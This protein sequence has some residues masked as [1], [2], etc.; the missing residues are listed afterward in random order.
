MIQFSLNQVDNGQTRQGLS[1]KAFMGHWGNKTNQKAQE[2]S[3]CF[4]YG[5]INTKSPLSDL[6]YCIE[7]HI[8]GGLKLKY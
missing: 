5:N 7:L 2:S 8:C 3:K 4:L 1:A 6:F